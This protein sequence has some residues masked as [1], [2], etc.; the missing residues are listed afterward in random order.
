MKVNK[1][2]IE[3]EDDSKIMWSPNHASSYA[4]VNRDKPNKFGEYPGYRIAPATAN[5]AHLT[6]VNS[7]NLKKSV[8]WASHNLYAVQHKDTE[9]RSVYAFSSLD[10]ARPV[11]DFDKFFDGE[12]LVQEDLVL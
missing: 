5:A 7:T 9:P 3:N 11:V 12:S 2:F 1:T 6:V 10:P 8:S 4:V